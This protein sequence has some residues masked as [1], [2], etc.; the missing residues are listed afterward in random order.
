MALE[1]IRRI[2][3]CE[4]SVRTTDLS[5][6]V[7]VQGLTCRHVLELRPLWV[8]QPYER[9]QEQGVERRSNSSVCADSSS[10]P[11]RLLCALSVTLRRRLIRCERKKATHTNYHRSQSF[12]AIS[13][14][15]PCVWVERPQRLAST[16][17][18]AEDVATLEWEDMQATIVNFIVQFC[19]AVA[20]SAAEL[21][22]CTIHKHLL[23]L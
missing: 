11:V 23:I 15:V 13:D 9:L 7:L 5:F 21:F 17:Q 6:G 10:V 12:D 1:Y 8:A 18:A 19:C 4:S 20:S 14:H 3:G 2:L 16:N 22:G